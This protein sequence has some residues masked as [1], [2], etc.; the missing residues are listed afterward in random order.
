LLLVRA[1]NTRDIVVLP[2]K[3]VDDVTKAPK[4]SGANRSVDSQVYTPSAGWQNIQVKAVYEDPGAYVARVI[5]P[6]ELP[7]R[8]D[9]QLGLPINIFY[10]FLDMQEGTASPDTI[11]AINVSAAE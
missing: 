10:D 2:S 5:Q 4:K 7:L 6:P 1:A 11:H 8:Y 9:E 3:I